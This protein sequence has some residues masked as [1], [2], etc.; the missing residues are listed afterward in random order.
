[1][2]KMQSLGYQGLIFVFVVLFN[3]GASHAFGN[4]PLIRSCRPEGF[5]WTLTSQGGDLPLCLVN[6]S[7]IGA[8]DILNFKENLFKSQSIRLFLN[9]P[10]PNDAVGV[11]VT[12]AG[13]VWS[14]VDS[15]GKTWKVCQLSD[16]S[17]IEIET[18]GRGSADIAN[19]PL[20]DLLLSR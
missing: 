17:L 1:M 10:L 15:E 11:C 3:L 16:S 2:K 7:G 8:Q 5:F 18:L 9:L 20:R 13:Q 14:G 12:Q 19:K 4:N 6:G